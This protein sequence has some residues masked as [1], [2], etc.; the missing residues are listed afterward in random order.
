M[1]LPDM[2]VRR[3]QML[4]A[5]ALIVIAIPSL[6]IYDYTQNNPKFCTTC[7]LM[8]DAYDTWSVSAMHDL[9][10]HECH[11]NDMVESLGHVV[12]VLTVN[13]DVVT[14]PTEIDN[15]LCEH[16]HASEDPQWLQVVNTAGH[17]VHFYGSENYA[18]CIDCHGLRLHTFTPPEETCLECHDES[19][20]QAEEIMETHCVACHQFT[21]TEHELIP[22]TAECLS[23]HNGRDD[24]GVSFPEEGHTDAQCVSCHNPH[25]EELTFDCSDCHDPSGDLHEMTYHYLCTTCHIPHSETTMREN[26]L[27]CHG[28]KDEHY[29]PA[30]CATCHN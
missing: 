1:Q 9:T 12:E 20:G 29:A 17:K 3:N 13:P 19:M 21:V 8:S 10:C 16:C 25:E 26:C 27:T 4:L 2:S 28:D 22:E 30:N 24:L 5:L 14:K 23:C 15:E 18:D 11:V 6:F 7:H